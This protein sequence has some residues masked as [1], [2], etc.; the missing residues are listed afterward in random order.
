MKNK[1]LIALLA[2]LLTLAMTAPAL[3]AEQDWNRS[4]VVDAQCLIPD[5]AI[6]VT[7]PSDGNLYINPLSIPVEINGKVEDGQI[8]SDPA[9]IENKT[10]VPVRVT[11][12]VTGAVKE[13]S[14]MGLSSSSTQ[15]AGLTR[16]RAFIYFEIQAADDPEQVAWDSEYDAVKHQVVRTSTKTKK[17][18]VT[19]GAGGES[20]CYGAFRLTGDCV[21]NPKQEWTEED[22][23]DVTIVFS[24]KPAAAS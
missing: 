14:T 6:E 11:T 1:K 12:S 17:N 24:F 10:E 19:L 8:I 5:I 9:W 15:G 16:K 20:G 22:G 3:A 2:A 4:T 23:V 7:V 18:I 21:E 13:G